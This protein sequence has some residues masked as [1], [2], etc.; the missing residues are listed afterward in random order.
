MSDQEAIEKISNDVEATIKECGV[1]AIRSLP[2]FKQALQLASGYRALLKLIDDEFVKWALLPL[3]GTRLGFLT[4]MDKEPKEKHYGIHVVKTCS[5][6]ALIRGFYLTGNEFNIIA[7]SFYGAKNGYERLVFEFP[8]VRDI[9]LQP[10]VPQPAGDKTALVPY[11]A[12]W[13][14]DG[15]VQRMECL[16]TKD[17]VDFRIPVRVNSGMGA[18]GV[19]GKAERKMYFRI[20]KRLYGSTFGATDGDVDGDAIVTTGEPA[21][22]PLPAGAVEGRRYSIGNGKGKKQSAGDQPVA[23]GAAAEPTKASTP[24]P[25]A[26]APADAPADLVDRAR[27]L[28]M[29][30]E[31]DPVWDAPDFDARSSIDS[32]TERE[33]ADAATWA[34]GY[35]GNVPR[36]MK[37]PAHTMLTA[38]QPG[39]EG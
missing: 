27:L 35:L 17:G 5:I 37:R 19:I 3:M 22:S 4:D 6:E 16:Q 28:Q 18:D 1:L 10:G 8:G 2:K 11:T 26:T 12:T 13:R 15:E 14:Q 39:E 9:I 7:G 29:L 36:N 20:Y 23:N 24:P 21:P 31:I 34:R 38:R 25:S 33:C 32:W 30:R